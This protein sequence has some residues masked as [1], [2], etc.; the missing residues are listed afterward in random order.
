MNFG[1]RGR[2]LVLDCQSGSDLSSSRDDQSNIKSYKDK[3][4][5]GCLEEI[6]WHMDELDHLAESCGPAEGEKLRLEVRPALLLHDAA[7][8]RNKRCLLAYMNHRVNSIRHHKTLAGTSSSRIPTNLLSEAESEFQQAYEQLRCQQSELYIG[9]DG[10]LSIDLSRSRL[11]P[12]QTMI[13]VRVKKSLGSI[14]LADSSTVNLEAG[15]VHFL[16]TTDVEDFIQQ[17]HLEIAEGE[18]S[19]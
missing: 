13:Q 3:S 16:P 7:I 6:T 9:E 10:L 5:R 14:V 8:R 4:V 17:G 11:P 18:E 12:T 19:F 1:Q 2:E 15:T